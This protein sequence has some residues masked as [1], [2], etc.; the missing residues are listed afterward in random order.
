MST[1]QSTEPEPTPDIAALEARVAALEQA[2]AAEQARRVYHEHILA[3][4]N[5]AIIVVDLSFHIQAWNPAAERIYGWTAAEVIGQRLGE[6]LQA[7]YFDTTDRMA[8]FA[9]LEQNGVWI[10]RGAHRHRDGHEVIIESSVRHLRDETGTVVGIVGINR[11]I[12]ARHQVMEA[13]QVSEAR[14]RLAVDHLPFPFVIYDADLRFQYVNAA[15][16]QMAKR[17]EHELL[18]RRDEEVFAEGFTKEYLPL[19]R[20][21]ATSHVVQ[22]GECTAL[23]NYGTYYVEV[24]YVPLL[25]AAG[26]L[27]QVLAIAQNLT[28]RVEAEAALKRSEANLRALFDSALQAQFLLDT[29]Y[30]VL[31]FNRVAAVAIKRISQMDIQVGDSILTYVNPANREGFIANYERCLAGEAISHEQQII[32]PNGQAEWYDVAYMPVYRDGDQN[33]LGVAFSALNISARK[34][35][36][37]ALAKREAELAGIIDSAMDAIITVDAERRIVLFNHAAEQMFG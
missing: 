32:Y 17:P 14:F 24:V 6:L 35:A 20:A 19:L 3:N 12:T 11:D 2:L 9:E 30:R 29:E 10:G 28:A 37:Q 31:A 7:R 23:G 26:A 27:Q 21:A 13:L 33:I 15:M 16:I 4:V 25:D 8:A 5:D 36:E 34:E 1:A 22:R 18:G